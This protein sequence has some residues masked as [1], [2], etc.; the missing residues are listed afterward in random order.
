MNPDTSSKGG[1]ADDL[2]PHVPGGP[3]T[4]HDY[5]PDGRGGCTICADQLIEQQD[6]TIEQ[7][8]AELDRL[9]ELL[10]YRKRETFVTENHHAALGRIEQQQ[11]RIEGYE[12]AL[13]QMRVGAVA[14]RAIAE[15]TGGLSEDAEKVLQGLEA[16]LGIALSTKESA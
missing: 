12:S 15:A 16:A 5:D 6:R 4:D 10:D 11:A 13:E 1:R 7:Q 9:R 14:I 2:F 3:A 8:Q